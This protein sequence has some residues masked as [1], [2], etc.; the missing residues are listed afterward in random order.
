MENTKLFTE[1]FQQ[2]IFYAIISSVVIHGIKKTI[3]TLRNMQEGQKLHRFYGIILMYVFGFVCCLF[4][5]SSLITNNAMKI[6]FGL[7]IGT[8]GIAC[9]DAVVKSVLGLIPNI[10]KKIFAEKS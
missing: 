3:K 5:K 4:L 2:I 1:L 8:V 7:I 10:T 6:F 9:Y